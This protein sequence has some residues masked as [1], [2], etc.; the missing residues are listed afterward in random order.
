MNRLRLVCFLLIVL[1]YALNPVYILA[2]DSVLEEA[3]QDDFTNDIEQ[4]DYSYIIMNEVMPNP[5]G[6]DSDYE[7]LELYNDFDEEID[8]SDCT[9]DL[10]DIPEG[11]SIGVESY[12]IA[13]KD[14]LDKDGDGQSFETR[15]GNGSGVW[16]DS[17]EENYSVIELNI[18]MKNSD[19]SVS[20]VC[21]DYEDT[22]EWENAE[23]GQSFSID[24]DGEWTDEYLVTPGQANKP[25][26]EI[27]Y[28]HDILITEVY[29][30]PYSTNDENEWIE[31]YNFGD[32]DIELEGWQIEDNSKKQVFEGSIIVKAKA[33]L[34]LELDDLSITLNNSGEILTLYDP[35]E[36]EVDSFEYEKTAKGISNIRKFTNGE[37]SIGVGVFQTKAVTK[38]LENIFVD[39]EDLFYGV[40]IL[41]I[42]D[43]RSYEI[44]E[45]VC[46][47]G[48]ITVEFGKLGSKIFYIQDKTGGIQIY[49]SK[50]DFWNDYKIGDEIQV[51]GELKETKGEARIY[52]KEENAIKSISFDNDISPNT[53]TT[54]DIGEGMEGV[55]VVI[56]GEIVETSGKS[57]YIDDGSGRVKILIKSSTDIE[58]PEKKKGQ[59][60]G[61]IGI[62]S[63]YGE[64]E[65]GSYRVL[66]RYVSDIIISDEPLSYGEVL[67][68]TGMDINWLR[69]SGFGFLG[70]ASIFMK[71]LRRKEKHVLY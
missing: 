5:E 16:G 52:V 18:S 56:T 53:T 42:R 69:L 67:A 28:S 47:N 24:E 1:L 40:E 9:I 49:L 13:A 60:A 51:L 64:D 11:T 14:L 63:Q 23:S 50:E 41:N 65:E 22:F 58:T 19:D 27:I 12:L 38:G 34:V 3:L 4:V 48:I 70:I 15:R 46:V 30:S 6:S 8:L 26:P 33:Y 25:I 29:P 62:V 68:V 43:A 71:Y 2:F 45:Q 37:Y 7:W 17:E 66:P 31:L 35:N 36:D 39:P 20:L 10:K 61:I 21:S 55:F 54:G 32:E 44:G 59:Y 57:F